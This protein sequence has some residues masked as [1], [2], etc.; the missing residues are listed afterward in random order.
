ME[1]R[2]TQDVMEAV[3]YTPGVT[4]STYGPDNRSWE[5]ILL[6]GFHAGVTGI[7]RDGAGQPPVLPVYYLD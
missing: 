7:Y 2:G 6:R 3:R 5:Y 1:A 4:T